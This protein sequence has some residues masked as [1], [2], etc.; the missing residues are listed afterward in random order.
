MKER[1]WLIGYNSKTF[2]SKGKQISDGPVT[3]LEEQVEK[4]GDTYQFTEG[5]NTTVFPVSSTTSHVEKL[6]MA[7]EE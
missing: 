5:G 7:S 4:V 6:Q 2:N 3:V 1:T